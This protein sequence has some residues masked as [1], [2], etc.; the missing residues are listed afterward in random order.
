MRNNSNIETIGIEDAVVFDK[1][2]EQMA[3]LKQLKRV[4]FGFNAEAEIHMTGQGLATLI[5]SSKELVEL[6]LKR[7]KLEFTKEVF[8]ALNAN[9]LENW[10]VTPINQLDAVSNVYFKN[11]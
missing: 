6:R 2:L 3:S 10:I 7:A 5:Q 4:S 11:P 8:A 1:V 9:G